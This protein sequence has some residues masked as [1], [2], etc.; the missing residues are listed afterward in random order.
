MPLFVYR[1]AL[2]FEFSDRAP[3]SLLGAMALPVL[4]ATWPCQRLESRGRIFPLVHRVWDSPWQESAGS[5][6][7]LCCKSA[8]ARRSEG[9]APARSA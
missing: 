6:D 5:K 7:S 2:V 1:V 9:R 4:C 8:V 3:P